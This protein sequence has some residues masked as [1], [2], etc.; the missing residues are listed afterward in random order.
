MTVT[1]KLSAKME[2]YLEAVYVLG[3]T[4]DGARVGDIARQVRVHK[5][6]ATA[7]LHTLAEQG[8]VDYTPYKPVKLARRGKQLGA[9]IVKRHE[10]LRR[11]LMEVLGVAEGVAEDTACKMEHVIPPDVVERFTAFADF[12]DKCPHAGARFTAGF[13]YCCQAARS[14]GGCEHCGTIVA[15]NGTLKRRPAPM[16][17]EGHVK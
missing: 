2:D 7:A 17:A 4:R 10:T 5:S 8:L 3:G 16:T 9:R 14:P 1:D 6:T 11:F 15:V 12:V 13:G